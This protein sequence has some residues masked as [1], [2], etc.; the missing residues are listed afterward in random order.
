LKAKGLGST[1]SS[2]A[3]CALES[4]VHFSSARLPADYVSIAV[5]IP[6]TLAVETWTVADLPHGWEQTPAPSVLQD[7]GAEWVRSGRT[8]VLRVPSA[9]IPDEFNVLLNPAHADAR[10]VQ[11]RAPE[12]FVFDPRLIKA[13]LRN[14]RRARTAKATKQEA[15][16]KKRAFRAK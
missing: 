11:A 5:E 4:F 2:R 1:A 14:P 10:H 15:S 6:E 13:P 8:A 16:A 12:P 9:V 7:M 3:L